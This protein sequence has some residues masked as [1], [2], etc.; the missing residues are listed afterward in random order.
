M[1]IINSGI[2]FLSENWLIIMAKW[3][4]AVFVLTVFY[5]IIKL[6]V[7]KVKYNIL[8]NTLQS[9]EYT[10]KVAN[11]LWKVIFVTLM[12]FNFLAVFQIVWFQVWLL[13]W[14]LS[15]A[16]WFAMENMIGNMI[17]GILIITHKKIKIWQSIK[18]LWSLNL[19]WTIEEI[20]IRY[21]IIRL[22][23]KTRLLVP[24]IILAAT[25]LQ[26]IKD[27]PLIRWDIK[28]KVSR[29]NEVWIL[30][31]LIL[32]AINEQ[33]WVT[34][35]WLTSVFMAN[36]DIDWV[37]MKWSYFIERKVW[38]S[39]FTLNKKIT[40]RIIELFRKFGIKFTYPNMV[41]DTE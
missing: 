30:K 23:D 24:S 34:Y 19:L 29:D 6:I 9:D 4:S 32:Q 20:H 13:I 16:I 17:A 10:H 1:N 31:Q 35:K 38:K 40:I 26:T 8:Q 3:L 25:P 22:M 21:T 2:T 18:L 41:V 37:V 39:S 5:L 14:W 28:I 7:K 12:I 33:P 11:L 36:F 15:L 27:N